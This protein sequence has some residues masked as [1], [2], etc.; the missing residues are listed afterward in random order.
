[1]CAQSFVRAEQLPRGK[2][3]RCS[4]VGRSREGHRARPREFGAGKGQ[5]CSFPFSGLWCFA[6][7]IFPLQRVSG[8]APGQGGG[9]AH[10]SEGQLPFPFPSPIFSAASTAWGRA[11]M[12]GNGIF[13][14]NKLSQER[15]DVLKKTQVD[16]AVVVYVGQGSAQCNFC[17]L[18]CSMDFSGAFCS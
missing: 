13:L 9:I 3:C 6:L 12:G 16:H 4:A 1:M 5:L 11:G 15:T 14:A 18:A 10:S 2:R 8:K 17:S 7:Q